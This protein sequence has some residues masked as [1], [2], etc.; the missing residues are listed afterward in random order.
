M[1]PVY[2]AIEAYSA[3][4]IIHIETNDG[5]LRAQPGEVAY[6]TA[7]TP[8]GQLLGLALVGGETG[9]GSAWL[10]GN[11]PDNRA[12]FFAQVIPTE[13]PVASLGGDIMI[14]ASLIGL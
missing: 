14:V 10:I 11:G 9:G 2:P 5:H 1:N 3:G 8:A 12:D 13:H 4:G 6:A 7:V